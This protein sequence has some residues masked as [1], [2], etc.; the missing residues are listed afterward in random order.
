MITNGVPRET[1]V[2]LLLLPIVVTIIA[3][4]RQVIGIKGFGIYTPLIISFAFLTTGLRYGITIFAIILIVGTFMRFVARR[5]RLLYLPRIAIVLIGVSLAILLMF[6]EGAHSGRIG[7]IHV[8]VFAILIMITLV[9]KFI[10]A[11]IERGAKKAVILTIETLFLSVVCFWV[12]SWMWLQNIV[13]LFPLAI[14]IGCILINI[15]LGKWTGL[16]VSEY[17]RFREVIKSIELPE[18]KKKKKTKSE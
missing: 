8:S 6:L 17:F 5:F 15:L 7:L 13:F 10:A 11:Q 2:L 12:I 18:E 14:I 16:R 9:E 3:F 4:A 1:I